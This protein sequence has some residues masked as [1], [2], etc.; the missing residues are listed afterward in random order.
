MWPPRLL[1]LTTRF[2]TCRGLLQPSAG[3]IKLLS[4]D[5]GA[6]IGRSGF[7]ATKRTAIE[8]QWEGALPVEA[9]LEEVGVLSG[10]RDHAPLLLD[11]RAPCEYAKG[12]IP[13][14]I[15][16]P[17]F[18]DAERAEVSSVMGRSHHL[19]ISRSCHSMRCHPHYPI[20]S[21]RAHLPTRVPCTQVGTLYKKEGHDVAV[22]RGLKLVDRKWPSLL[23]D[24]PQLSEAELL[25]TRRTVSCS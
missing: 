22:K 11:V 10:R 8:L 17:L 1:V 19:T 13:G 24:V 20:A 15:S 5:L 25:I 18:S 14:A 9:F 21:K 12:H 2:A 4:S 16:L 3:G 23:D 7:E 6:V